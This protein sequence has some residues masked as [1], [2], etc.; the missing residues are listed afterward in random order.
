MM[1]RVLS[2]MLVLWGANCPAA[3]LRLAL[4]HTDL[5]RKG[6]GLL[7]RDIAK[8][9]DPQVNAVIEVIAAVR[10]DVLLLLDVDY[11]YDGAALAAL[12]RALTARGVVFAHRFAARPNTGMATGLDLDANGYLGDAADAQGFGHFSGQGGMALLSRWPILEQEVQD[13]SAF[14]WR[15][16]PGADLPRTQAGPFPSAKAQAVQRLSTTGHWV[17]PIQPPSGTPI[18]VL[19]YHAGPPAFEGPEQRNTKRNGDETRLWLH[20]LNGALGPRPERRFVVM[21]GANQAPSGAAMGALLAH[22]ALQDPAPRSPGSLRSAGDP[23][24]TVF[25][26]APGP[27]ARRVDYVLPSADWQV[28]EAGVFWPDEDTVAR[29]ASRHRLVWV[30]LQP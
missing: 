12:Q 21:G 28:V 18:Y 29:A 22:P 3:P 10:P 1:L 19:A 4:F 16:L 13:F 7:L 24:H 14:L 8:G 9:D 5:E 2:L 23:F 15:D 25:W 20:Y 11:D 17:V 27:G 6:P 30:D 26:P